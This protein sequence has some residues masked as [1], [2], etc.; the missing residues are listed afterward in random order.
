MSWSRGSHCS[1]PERSHA[2]GPLHGH[3]Q[4]C[5]K[6]GKGPLRPGKAVP[7]CPWVLVTGE[8]S[9]WPVPKCRALGLQHIWDGEG[10][11][12]RRGE[13]DGE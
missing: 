12:R 7:L 11:R 3:G 1:E 6:G 8:L 9:E 13:G 4:P 2:V 5:R 10:T